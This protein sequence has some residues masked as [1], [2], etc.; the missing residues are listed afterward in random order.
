MSTNDTITP[1]RIPEITSEIADVP[2]QLS[3]LSGSV[4]LQ[5][6]IDDRTRRSGLQHIA[7][8]REQMAVQAAARRISS[9][10]AFKREAAP[11]RQIAA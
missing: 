4:P 3:L 5:F 1:S 7:Q 10:P 9:T 6:R 8:L 2:E 11:R